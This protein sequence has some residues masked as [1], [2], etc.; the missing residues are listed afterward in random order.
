[1][2]ERIPGDESPRFRSG[3]PCFSAESDA[4]ASDAVVIFQD[5][6]TRVTEI[7][8]GL[9]GK[10]MNLHLAAVRALFEGTIQ[11]PF[12]FL[13]NLGKIILPSQEA[14]TLVQEK[15]TISF[16]PFVLVNYQSGKQEE[17]NM[18]INLLL[19]W[20]YPTGSGKDT[21]PVTD[22]REMWLQL[23]DIADAVIFPLHEHFYH[24]T[25]CVSELKYVCNRRAA[26]IIPLRLDDVPLPNDVAITVDQAKYVSCDSIDW[27]KKL[28]KV[29]KLNLACRTSRPPSL[30]KSVSHTQLQMKAEV[31]TVH[32]KMTD[33]GWKDP[34]VVAVIGSQTLYRKDLTQ[35]I[36]EVL[37]REMRKAQIRG[38]AIVVLTLGS[39]GVPQMMARAFAGSCLREA[40]QVLHLLSGQFDR[41]DDLTEPDVGVCMRFANRHLSQLG[42]IM[43]CV[44]D[45]LI[46]AE[47]SPESAEPAQWFR[48]VIPLQRFGGAAGYGW[49]RPLGVRAELWNR[50]CT[51]HHPEALIEASDISNMVLSMMEDIA[52]K[53]PPPPQLVYHLTDRNQ[54]QEY[55]RAFDAVYLFSRHGAKNQLKDLT[56]IEEKLTQLVM[57]LNVRHG[58]WIALYGGDPCVE[59]EDDIGTVMKFLKP[60]CRIM[61]IQLD[62]HREDLLQSVDEGPYGHLRGCHVYFAPTTFD[63]RNNKQLYGGTREGRPVGNSAVWFGPYVQPHLWGHVVLGGGQVTLE[64]Y[65]WCEKHKIPTLY[66][67]AAAKVTHET[68][69]APW[70]GEVHEYILQQNL[71]ATIGRWN[72]W[73]Q[74]PCQVAQWRLDRFKRPTEVNATAPWQSACS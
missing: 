67:Q 28:C 23:A 40:S 15:V 60:R 63:A 27:P 33:L 62:I 41:E 17:M 10:S 32:Q 1:M 7:Q 44:A 5:D 65:Q 37:G 35:P 16:K 30:L 53:P 43:A 68:R 71:E 48:N 70:Y 31:N 18:V 3:S 66:I 2:E 12:L 55:L 51:P 19:Q 59:G 74:D 49:H 64:D 4:D 14:S 50:V 54:L 22:S 72:Y 36:C 13:D 25:V 57:D 69:P 61:A 47:D 45:V 6:G 21:R 58:K 42:R 20:G 38:R 9:L 24:S 39:S 8:K 56:N 11:Q 34:L 46:L 52:S 29:L 73:G 26:T